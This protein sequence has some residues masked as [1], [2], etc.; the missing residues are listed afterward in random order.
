[1]PVFLGLLP[2]SAA[3]AAERGRSAANRSLVMQPQ[4]RLL[5]ESLDGLLQSVAVRAGIR[6]LVEQARR[7]LAQ[8]RA[9]GLGAHPL[10]RLWRG[11]ARA[12]QV[13]LGLHP[14]CDD[15]DGRGTPPE[16][17]PTD[18]G[19]RGERRPAN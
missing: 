16:Q 9:D 14:P 19:L 2:L 1:M 10:A 13:Q 7:E 12:D 17:S 4:E 8:G 5:L 6:P 15:R 3:A 18:G 11:L